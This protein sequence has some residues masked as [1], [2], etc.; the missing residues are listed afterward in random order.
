[1]AYRS[2]ISANLVALI[3]SWLDVIQ[4]EKSYTRTSACLVC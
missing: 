1:V 2:I 4:S 3:R